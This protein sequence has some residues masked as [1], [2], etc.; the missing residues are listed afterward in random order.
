LAP[1]DKKS[2]ANKGRGFFYLFWQ[3]DKPDI[4]TLGE[5][6]GFT[7]F[8]QTV[9]PAFFDPRVPGKKTRLF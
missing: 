4:L 7:G 5:L 6:R 1:A 2:P 9:L 3:P 8:F